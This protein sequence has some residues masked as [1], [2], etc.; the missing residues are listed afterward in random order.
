MGLWLWPKATQSQKLRRRAI[1]RHA[2]LTKRREMILLSASGL[3][4]PRKT[5]NNTKKAGHCDSPV[6]PVNPHRSKQREQSQLSNT[7]LYSFERSLHCLR[8]LLFIGTTQFQQDPERGCSWQFEQ[9]AVKPKTDR[10]HNRSRAARRFNPIHFD[11]R[12]LSQT[13]P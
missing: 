4:K 13:K 5:S 1:G 6:S 7:R 9:T 10:Q 3:R 12:F 2:P 11:F 8:Y